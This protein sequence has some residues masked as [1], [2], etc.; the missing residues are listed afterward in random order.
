MTEA[1]VASAP[2]WAT[3][4]PSRTGWVL[5]QVRLGIL[6]GEFVA[7]QPLVEAELAARYGVSKTPVREAL[8]TLA[9]QGLVRLGDFKGATVNAVDRAMVHDVF[10][11]RVLLEPAAVA[12]AVR[13]GTDLSEARDLLDRADGAQTD[14]ERSVLN[15]EFHRTLY[16]GCGN[17]LMVEILDGLRERTALIS[18]ALWK[19]ERSWDTEAHEHVALWEAARTG[20]ADEAE[21][22]TREHIEQFAARCAA[23]L[24]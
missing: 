3:P 2:R 13:S 16:A 1:S 15:R 17:R 21:R 11:V 8:K 5:E 23:R 10:G 24:G 14:A 9:G 19:S 22:L 18:V 20:D 12:A 7:G 4:M 6:S